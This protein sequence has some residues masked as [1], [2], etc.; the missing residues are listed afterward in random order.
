M[1]Y[2]E[3]I[4]ELLGWCSVVNIAMLFLS[5]ILLIVM[6]GWITKIHA[7]LS[8]VSEDDLPSIYLHF[9]GNYKLL[10]LMFNLVP[11][12]ALRLSA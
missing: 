8:G 2:I 10:I 11:Y 6:R 3:M 12:I 4:T 1:Y 9:L 5:S 7:K